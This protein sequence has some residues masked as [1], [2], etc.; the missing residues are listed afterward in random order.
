MY[1]WRDPPPHHRADSRLVPS[2]WEMLLQSNTVSHWLR[3]NLES[4]LTTMCWPSVPECYPITGQC[5]WAGLVTQAHSSTLHTL[6]QPTAQGSLSW[7]HHT[8]NF[9][10]KFAKFYAMA[11][12]WLLQNIAHAMTAQ[13]LWY[14]QNS[15]AITSVWFERE[16]KIFLCVGNLKNLVNLV[17]CNLWDTKLCAHM[18]FVNI[19]LGNSLA[20]WTSSIWPISIKRINLIRRD[21]HLMA[22]L[23]LVNA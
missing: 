6:V 10:P 22:N 18:Q 23:M 4:A 2:Q 7:S 5:I 11:C 3:A 8:N 12:I 20:T 19:G 9:W 15:V 1:T 13:L 14:V 17:H 16:P 21:W